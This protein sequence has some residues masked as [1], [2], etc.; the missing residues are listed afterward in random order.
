MA[1]PGL[2]AKN[3]TVPPDILHVSPSGAQLGSTVR[4]IV[5]GRNLAEV[6][7]VLFSEPGMQ[8]EVVN[9]RQLPKK[10]L[11]DDDG[12]VI[13]A[14]LYEAPSYHVTLKV[15]ISS[16]V[17]PG[18]HSFRML[19]PLGITEKV[20]FV[21][22]EWTEVKE[23]SG[24][25]GKAAWAELP[26]TLIGTLET[27]GEVDEFQFYAR[28]GQE[29]V[30]QMTAAK[31][32]SELEP[33]VEVLDAQGR[34]VGSKSVAA[35]RDV[36]LGIAFTSEGRYTLR[37][38]DYEMRG[39]RDFYYRVTAGELPYL[40]SFFPLGVP[41]GKPTEVKLKGFNL[42]GVESVTVEP[43]ASAELW[44]TFE[45]WI[46]TPKGK[47]LNPIRLAVGEYPEILEKET[48][49]GLSSGTSVQMPVVINGRIDGGPSQSPADEDLFRF[50][51]RKGQKI[52]LEVQA[53]R[54]GSPLDS[55]IEVLDSKGRAIPRTTLRA[56]LKTSVIFR[57]HD[58]VSSDIRMDQVKGLGVGDY[59]LIDD[60]VMQMERLP[61]Q[62]DEDHH[63][64]KFMGRRIAAFGTTPTAHPLDAPAYKVVP[65]PTGTTFPPNGIAGGSPCLGAMTTGD[66]CSARTP[67]WRLQCP[68]TGFTMSVCRTFKALGEETTSTD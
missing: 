25:S 15:S 35:N 21:V 2:F 54:L 18:I 46:T 33:I 32:G 60:E 7:R 1:C 9:V 26:A 5:E 65:H 30:F 20:S 56:V 31:I 40:T 57:S 59:I 43:P 37:I 14:V 34:K 67:D 61:E 16:E 49:S 38:S 11:V 48:G 52:I 10:E 50:K 12:F 19:T 28:E 23:S 36:V 55:L 24:M 45:T 29:V 22:G 66:P 42:A 39:G 47:S 53:D 41:K 3:P 17:P 63:F 13:P 62:P 4:V 27:P 58:S 68:K 8:A 6:R 44:D 64:R 51:A